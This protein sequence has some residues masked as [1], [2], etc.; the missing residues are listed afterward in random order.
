VAAGAPPANRR[1]AAPHHL[2]GHRVAAAG[3]LNPDQNTS[4][5][6][7]PFTTAQLAGKALSRLVVH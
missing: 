6:L 7:G 4:A 1:R 5:L 3:E 2:A